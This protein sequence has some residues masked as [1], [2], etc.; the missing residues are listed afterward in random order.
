VCRLRMAGGTPER[1][2]GFGAGDRATNFVRRLRSPWAVATLVLFVAHLWLIRSVIQNGDGA[3][4]NEQIERGI[5][6]MRTTHVGYILCGIV[7]HALSPFDTDGTMNVVCLAFAAAGGAAMFMIARGLGASRSVAAVAPLMA[8]GIQAY[9]RGAVLAEVDVVACSLVLIAVALWL[10]GKVAK[11]GV[12]FG[13]A[14]LVTPITAM[15]IPML[16][17]T[18]RERRYARRRWSTHLR[19]V[20]VFGAVSLA[21]YAPLAIVFWHDYWYGG[22]GLLHAP[23]EPWS[24]EHQVARSIQF[25]TSSAGPWL[26]LGVGALVAGIATGA[27]PSLGVS[28]A[29]VL[30]ATVGERFLDVP[31]QL[32]QLCVLA[33]LVVVVAGRLPAPWLRWGVLASLWLSTAWPTYRDVSGEVHADVEKREVY[34]AMIGQTPKMILAGVRDGWDDGLPFERVAY[35]RTKLGLGLSYGD[36]RNKA[37]SIVDARRDHA[38][39]LVGAPPPGAMAPFALAWRPEKR[40]VRGLDYAVWVPGGP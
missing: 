27:P 12:A 19:D 40:R 37:S 14:M 28:A 3:V 26:A 30:A 9:L 36:L 33:A 8:F 24:V 25:L 16:L 39:W 31:V 13:A 18:T 2:L 5:V 6:G 10:Q 34:R 17:L 21:V 23:R 11:A 4:Y 7:A 1:E 20:A 38:I 32:P 29:L 35:G 15:S 22:R